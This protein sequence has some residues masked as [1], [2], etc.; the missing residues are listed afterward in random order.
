VIN[1]NEKEHIDDL[2]KIVKDTNVPDALKNVLY[3]N[4]YE[5]LLNRKY[6]NEM[7]IEF[8][9]K[10]NYKI[11]LLE[12]NIKTETKKD[13]MVDKKTFNYVEEF[14]KIQDINKLEYI[15]LEKIINSNKKISKNDNNEYMK[16]K[17]KS[18]LKKDVDV[19]LLAKIY[20]DVFTVK[21]KCHW[22]YN[23]YNMINKTELDLIKEDIKNISEIKKL[24]SVQ[25][26]IIKDVVKILGIKHCQD[27]ETLILKTIIDTKLTDY[28]LKNY[29]DICTAFGFA[30]NEIIKSVINDALLRDKLE[31][32]IYYCICNVLYNFG[33]CKLEV[34]KRDTHSHKTLNYKLNGIN[35]FGL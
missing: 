33:G 27:N 6:F 11:T 29:N 3:F 30:K 19:E 35:I 26:K 24:L 21:H 20:F 10:C 18:L 4:M 16:F 22:F 15:S 13:K 2:I 34:N 1:D 23:V 28:I 7:F 14:N 25:F 8:L 9:K 17:L 32:S 5:D 31:A 12:G